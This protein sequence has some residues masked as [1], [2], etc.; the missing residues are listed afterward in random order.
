MFLKRCPEAVRF[1]VTLYGS[2]AAT[3]R[4]HM[5][6]VGILRVLEPVGETQIIWRPESYLFIQTE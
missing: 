4:G 6:D 1:V 2:L 5:T 3:G